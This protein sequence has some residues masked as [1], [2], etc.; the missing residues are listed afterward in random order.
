MLQHDEHER[1]LIIAKIP[2]TIPLGLPLFATTL[3]NHFVTVFSSLLPSD[4]GDGK[5]RDSFDTK[6]AIT[7]E[8]YQQLLVHLDRLVN[9]LVSE[10][11]SAN[12]RD[13]S[14]RISAQIA[15]I[16]HEHI[17]H[18]HWAAT[19]IEI[20][21]IAELVRIK[22]AADDQQQPL[23]L[24]AANLEQISA[25]VKSTETPA[26]LNVD[27]DDIILKVLNSPLLADQIDRRIVNDENRKSGV[28]AELLVLRTEIESIKGTL[29]QRFDGDDSSLAELRAQQQK[30][31]DRINQLETD[32]DVRLMRF[33]AEIDVKFDAS[34]AGQF[35]AI[36]GHVKMML[37]KVMGG[38]TGENEVD[39]SAM[40]VESMREMVRRVFV[41]KNELE[42]QLSAVADRVTGQT[43]EELDRSAGLLMETIGDRIRVET[44][45]VAEQ[46]TEEMRR[47]VGETVTIS[48]ESA[49]H[50]WSAGGGGGV[51]DEAIRRIVRD[52][53]AV[54]DADKTGLV[55]YALESAG[56][57]IISTR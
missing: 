53:L 56:G 51:D 34:K 8:Q 21:R 44:E 48:L 55:D 5:A 20:E 17:H 2:S 13:T 28:S 33:L 46:S 29:R 52:A 50:S 49:Q 19:D 15:Q 47:V 57:E 38:G 16:V 39:G 10:K 40:S 6:S 32:M 37:L 3:R 30:L 14:A 12:E 35:A 31:S 18:H 26:H 4:D 43:R 45:R 36:D 7:D 25:I 23:K 41:A 42:I 11:I 24:S 27:V 9:R 22:L 1:K 54:Y